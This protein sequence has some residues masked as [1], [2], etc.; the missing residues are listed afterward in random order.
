LRDSDST[1]MWLFHII[2]H[3]K[4][5]SILELEVPLKKKSRT[6]DDDMQEEE[7]KKKSGSGLD[8][9]TIVSSYSSFFIQLNRI[10]VLSRT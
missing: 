3:I 9:P 4:T 10:S 5:G 2:C 7:E 6:S 1:H 8:A